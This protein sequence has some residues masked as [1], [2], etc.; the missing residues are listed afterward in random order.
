[1]REGADV[2]WRFWLDGEPTVSTYRPH[3]PRRR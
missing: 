1:V 2:P 3:V